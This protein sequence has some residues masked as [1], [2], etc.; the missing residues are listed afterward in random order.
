MNKEKISH[1]LTRMGADKKSK[2]ACRKKAQKAQRQNI[3]SP[4]VLFALFCG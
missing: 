1:R 2:S 3:E 4:L